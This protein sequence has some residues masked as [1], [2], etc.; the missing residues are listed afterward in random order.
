MGRGYEAGGAVE[1]RGSGA[2]NNPCGEWP[3]LNEG[4]E[5][6]GTPPCTKCLLVRR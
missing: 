3:L 4:G 2:R 5:P 6:L 1:E